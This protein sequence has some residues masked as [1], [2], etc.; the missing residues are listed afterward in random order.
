MADAAE[1]CCCDGHDALA[2]VLDHVQL[3]VGNRGGGLGHADLHLIEFDVW[4]S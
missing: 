1:A 3:A 4:N 2:D